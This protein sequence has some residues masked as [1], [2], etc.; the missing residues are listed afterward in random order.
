[1]KILLKLLR[2]R[3]R[4]RNEMKSGKIEKKKEKGEILKKWLF[5]NSR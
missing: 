5:N 2:E 1:M 4:S 3:W